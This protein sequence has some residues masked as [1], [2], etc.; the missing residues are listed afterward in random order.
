[1]VRMTHEPMAELM[2]YQ[3]EH[4]VGPT[5]Y[6]QLLRPGEQ[7]AAE[8]APVAWGPVVEILEEA[9]AVRVVAELPGVQPKDVS[10]WL[11]GRRLTITG[12]KLQSDEQ[13]V[14]K[15][16]RDERTYGEF[17]RSFGLSSLVDF[18]GVTA[19]SELGVLTII[20]PK[21]DSAKRRQIPVTSQIPVTVAIPVTV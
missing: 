16:L 4:R 19:T 1:M 17:K 7:P 20:L 14:L 13:P 11:E 12:T 18:K 10:V 8:T 21:A 3:L 9:D 2:L 6:N 5:F 15:V